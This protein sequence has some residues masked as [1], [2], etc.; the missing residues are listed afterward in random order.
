M[1]IVREHEED[2]FYQYKHEDEFFQIFCI[3]IIVLTIIAIYHNNIN[4]Y[5]ICY[6]VEYCRKL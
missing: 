1:L 5:T 2:E 3:Y 4:L 6:N